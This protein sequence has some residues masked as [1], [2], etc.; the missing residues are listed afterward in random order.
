MD[1][2][3]FHLVRTVE[4]LRAQVRAWRHAEL[5]VGLVPTMGALH[6]GHMALLRT[7]LSTC[8]RVVVT[9]FVNPTQFS[10]SEDFAA[11][12][13][14]EEKDRRLIENAGGHLLFAPA[15]D[16]MYTP[17]DTTKVHVVAFETQLE[18]LYRPGHLT[19]VATVV[20]KFLNQVQADHAFFGEK[21]FQQL[22]VIRRLVFDLCIDT[23]IHG[24]ATVR[25]AGGLALSS[26]NAHL[27]RSERSQASQLYEALEVVARD[28]RAGKDAGRLELVAREALLK[29]GFDTVDYVVVVDAFTLQ[30]LNDFDVVRPARVLAAVRMGRV[31]LLDNVG[32]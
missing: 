6:D 25:E 1:R 22:Q 13:R 29:A 26:R 10:E 4:A 31:R 20:A 24:V 5:S 27:T 23:E 9:V 19:G 28:F 2:E 8:D 12:P 3:P 21:D 30:P 15:P 14:D 11:Y 16:E 18:G 7:A 32:V 17:G